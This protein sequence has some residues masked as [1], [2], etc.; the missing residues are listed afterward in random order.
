V[1]WTFSEGRTTEALFWDFACKGS[2]LTRVRPAAA[3]RADPKRCRRACYR[4]PSATALHMGKLFTFVIPQHTH[5]KHVLA[6]R[7]GIA[8][9]QAAPKTLSLARNTLPQ[10][11]NREI[12]CSIGL[13]VA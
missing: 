8:A 1:D 5:A 13:A 11:R 6:L 3:L 4:T 10:Q 2:H 9:L 7:Y 12:S